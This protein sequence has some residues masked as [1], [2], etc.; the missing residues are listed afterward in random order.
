MAFGSGKKTHIAGRVS[1]AL[2]WNL[3]CRGQDLN[4]LELSDIGRVINFRRMKNDQMAKIQYPRNCY[5][6]R[7]SPRKV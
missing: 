7:K 2:L 3:I 5:V 1:L 6:N 4:G